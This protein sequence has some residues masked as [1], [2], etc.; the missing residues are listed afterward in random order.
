MSKKKR[1]LNDIPIYLIT[2]LLGGF[3][4]MQ[5]FIGSKEQLPPPG[6]QIIIEKTNYAVKQPEFPS[7]LTFASEKVPL[8]L[9]DVKESLDRE[10]IT[11]TYY[12][13]STIQ[14]LKLSKRYF[15]VIDSILNANNIPE[16]FKYLCVIESSLRNATSPSGAKGLW[17]FMQATGREHNLEINSYVDERYNLEKST[18][19]ACEYL[20][21]AY[22]KFGS[23]TL[24]AAS[25][26]MG[27]AKLQRRLNEQKADNY[28][29]LYLNPETA[30]YIYWILA[31]KTIMSEHEKY[32]FHITSKEKYAPLPVDTLI[33]DIT[34]TDLVEFAFQ[35]GIN[36]KILKEFNP[37]LINTYLTNRSGK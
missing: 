28:Y 12:H 34:I 17:Q 10:L 20:Q 11:N 9:F 14:I 33:V 29:D 5:L 18:V 23:W 21:K 24:A 37:W 15:P 3:V 32:G 16:D 27:K 36:Y 26:N 19:A 25:Y 8:D 4:I 2:V 6:N 35:Q 22:D 30:R 1:F 7:N 13:S 31:M